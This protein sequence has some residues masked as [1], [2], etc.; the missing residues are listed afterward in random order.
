MCNSESMVQTKSIMAFSKQGLRLLKRPMGVRG[1]SSFPSFVFQSTKSLVCEPGAAA[2]LGRYVT[3][4]LMLSARKGASVLVV[5]DKGIT[6]KGLELRAFES[7]SEHGF[8]VVLFDDVVADPPEAVIDSAVVLAKE[9]KAKCVIGFGGGSSMD[10]AK[11]V[12]FLAHP[13]A[14]QKLKDIYGVG[15]CFG[16]RLPLV[17]IPTTAGT[18]SEVTPISIV[19]TGKKEKKGIVSPV[20]LPDLALLDGELTLS[21]LSDVTSATGVDAMVHA[22]EAYTSRKKKNPLSDLLAREALRLLGANIV[23]ACEDPQNLNARSNMLLGSMYAGMAFANAPVAAV[24]ALAYPIGSHFHVPHGLSNS[25]MLPHVLRFNDS[26]AS[27]LYKELAPII[28]PESPSEPLA[29]N[30]DRLAKRLNMPRR[31]RDVGISKK[32]VDMLANE[33][34]KQTRLL[35]NNP[36]EVELEDAAT[37]Y[38]QAL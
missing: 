4:D 20:L 27:T 34:M 18:G 28:F 11:L 31:L 30:I 12:A 7:L 9:I 19:T 29:D 5:S 33:A 24:H 14:S 36:R 16:S 17:Q 25:L 37:L 10:V 6:E 15:A 26:A 3:E 2:R 23:M 13:K 38:K 8:D 21:L 1:L 35:P 22:I 32:D